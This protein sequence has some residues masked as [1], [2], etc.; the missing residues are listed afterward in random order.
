MSK[1]LINIKDITDNLFYQ[2][3]KQLFYSETYRTKLSANAKLLYAIIR[4][5]FNSSM[6]NAKKKLENNQKASFV[7]NKGDVYCIVDNHE[8]EFTLNITDKT[9]TKIMKELTDA[10]LIKTVRVPNKPKRIYLY[11]LESTPLDAAVFFGKKDYYSYVRTQKK[12]KEVIEITEEEYIANRINHLVDRENQ[13]VV[14]TTTPGNVETT[15]PETVKT[16]TSGNVNST[17]PETD[18]FRHNDIYSNNIY[19]NENH[20]NE[21]Y[22]N[23]SSSKD[24]NVDIY[25]KHI[26]EET[27]QTSTIKNEYS[28][29]DTMLDEQG[30]FTL[31]KDRNVI[32]KT[33]RSANITSLSEKIIL[34]ALVT[35]RAN[36]IRM[37]LSEGVG[38]KYEP[39]YF[40]NNLV[41]RCI[42][43]QNKAIAQEEQNL[44]IQRRQSANNDTSRTIVPFYNW[45]EE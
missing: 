9:V 22:L 16:T 37:Q 24:H 35:H 38:P 11:S 12:R 20:S 19:S 31:P 21:T 3:P 41:D 34:N 40:A 39:A 36:I 43:A 29:L 1:K 26:E 4:D 10:E 15:T 44:A 14:K 28:I 8:I 42:E 30:L 23:D 33:L 27:E 25:T 7:D 5:R 6:D 17:T 45:L 32:K 2:L 13:G 18:N